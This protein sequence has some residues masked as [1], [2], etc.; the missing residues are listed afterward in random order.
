MPTCSLLKWDSNFSDLSGPQ[1][2]KVR[3]D[4]T[5]FHPCMNDEAHYLIP[6]LHLPVAPLCNIYCKFCNRK[7][8]LNDTKTRCP[9]LAGRILTPDQA[10]KKTRQ[11]LDRFG[12]SGIIGIA[13]PG[14]PLANQ[15][16]F[17]TFELIRK[18]FPEAA[19][20]L[21]TNGLNLLGSIK[22]L[23]AL[24]IKHLSISMNGLLPEI[25]AKITPWVK[26]NGRII[27][28]EEGARVLIEN[29]LAGIR[30]AVSCYMFVKI[31]TVVI[32]R[33]NGF[34]VE[35]IAETVKKLG[36]GL[37]NPVPLIQGDDWGKEDLPSQNYM[38]ALQNKCE[39][40]LP[41]FKK[42]RQCRADAEGIPGKEACQ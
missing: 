18:A 37:F 35:R 3:Q 1:K 33:I 12:S 11:F 41:V 8:S 27:K 30:A 36:V 34:H 29:Q 20:C 23:N 6:R 26:V 22:K 5:P 19:F 21:C 39:S 7:I 4:K 32:P 31:N 14:D 10:L 13:G 16:T 38:T 2:R 40:F 25:V 9:G 42:C 17:K 24:K 28:G 15:E